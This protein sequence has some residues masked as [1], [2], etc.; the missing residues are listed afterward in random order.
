MRE[1]ILELFDS[2]SGRIA[3]VK[4]KMKLYNQDVD[5]QAKSEELYMAVC[6]CILH[7]TKWLDKKSSGKW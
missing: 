1:D 5:L 4:Q 6:N 3:N 2:L 7:C